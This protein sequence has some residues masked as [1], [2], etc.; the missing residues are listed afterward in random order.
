[1]EEYIACYPTK[2]LLA[3]VELLL[4]DTVIGFYRVCFDHMTYS[5]LLYSVRLYLYGKFA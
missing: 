1:M 4:Y 3:D 5:E 2:V